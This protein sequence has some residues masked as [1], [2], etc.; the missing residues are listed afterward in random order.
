L[1]ENKNWNNAMLE[2][3]NDEEHKTEP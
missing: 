3:W 2:Y 1:K